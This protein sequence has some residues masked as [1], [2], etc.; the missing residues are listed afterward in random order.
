[1]LLYGP[2]DLSFEKRAHKLPL[3]V[4]V[5][6]LYEFRVDEDTTAVFADDD[7]LSELKVY[8]TLRW[9]LIEATTTSVTINRHHRQTIA[10]PFTKASEGVQKTLLNALFQA[11][12]F[13][14]ESFLFL[15]RF[16]LDT[17]QLI[18][19]RFEVY[20][21]LC[22]RFLESSYTILAVL[23][24]GCPFGDALLR[25][26]NLQ[27]LELNLLGEVVVFAVIL[28]VVELLLVLLDALFSLLDFGF[29]RGYSLYLTL[30]VLSRKRSQSLAP[31]E[32]VHHGGS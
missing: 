13:S 7:L 16:S 31:Q 26:L 21:T 9:N 29:L 25:E 8:L 5:C 19:L 4:L 12:R 14:T 17:R 22:D 6:F 3:V 10:C 1:M 24:I 28:D 23:Y 30:V 11:N 20:A 27:T 18:L 15:L 32:E 2:L